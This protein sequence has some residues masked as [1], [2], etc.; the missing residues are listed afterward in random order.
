MGLGLHGGAVGTVRFLSSAGAQITVTDIKSKEELLPSVE[1]LKGVKNVSFVFNQHRPE[2][3]TSCD[4]VVK[5]PAASWSNKYIKMAL[6]KGVS[7][8]SDSSLFFKLCPCDIIGVTGT[9]GKTTTATLIFEILKAAGK[10]AVK[11]G[12]G[13]VS[14]LDKLDDLEKKSVAVFEIS[15]WR[16]SAIGRHKL[17]PKVAVITN[18]FP[19]HLNYYKTMGEYIKD[20][21]YIFQ[22]Q[23]PDG[24]CVINGD[25]EVIKSLEPEIKSRIIKFFQSKT[26]SGYSVYL[27]Q[28]S[29]Y[30]NSGVD[31]KKVVDLAAVKLKGAHNAANIMAAVGAVFP[32]D[33]DIK[34]M[35]EAIENFSGVSHR[36]E[37]VREIDGVKYINDTTATTPEASISGLETFLEPVVLIAGGVDKNLDVNGFARAICEKAKGVVFLK[38][39]ATDKIISAIRKIRCELKEDDFRVVES[40]EKAVELAKSEATKGDVVLLSPGAASF[41]LFKNEFDRGDKF[42]EAVKGLK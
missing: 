11:V 27:D 39:E 35:R 4:M 25:D 1:K 29:V 15:S 42:K 9:K 2:D 32:Y 38:G 20:K 17:S 28:G 10:K 34:I 14:V 23:K 19:D 13:Q 26:D 37:M 40:M 12:I 16:L 31:E 5:N 3:F 7:V 22:N 6:E 41:G 24:W 18:I 33:V 8:E 21:K 30:L 36:L